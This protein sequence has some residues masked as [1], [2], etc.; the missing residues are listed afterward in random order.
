M[1][2]DG[3]GAEKGSLFCALA[4]FFESF[5][6]DALLKEFPEPKEP[7]G[8][9]STLPTLEKVPSSE[10]TTA[11]YLRWLV[12]LVGDL[13]QPLHW[14]HQYGHGK[15]IKIRFRNSETT[16]LTLWEDMLAKDVPKEKGMHPDQTDK[17]YGS[18]SS[19]WGNTVPTELFRTWAKEVAEQLCTEVYKP[20]TVNHADGTR[21]ENPFELPEELYT[22][23]VSLAEKLLSLGG[24]RLAF[25]LNEIIEHKRHKEAHKDGRGLPSRKVA[26]GTE[27]ITSNAGPPTVL[28]QQYG[29]GSEGSGRQPADIGMIYKQLKIEERR[30][31]FNNAL[32][33]AGIA[34]VLVPSL[35]FTL[36]WHERI[37]GGSVLR[38]TKHLKL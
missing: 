10:K 7:I 4:Y 5:A 3:H 31:S 30:R 1:R 2:C 21:V 27:T 20:M 32:C 35:L 36:V 17:E 33:N 14:L 16:L 28:N 6:H 26:V 11:N 8:T 37:G 38:L 24:E 18:R 19:S 29:D 23:W 13:H 15:D 25:I 12:I 34:V 9:P 22:K